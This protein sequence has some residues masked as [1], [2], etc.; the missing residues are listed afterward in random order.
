MQPKHDLLV[1]SKKEILVVLL[2]LILV[3]LFSFTIGLKLGKSLASKESPV[4]QQ[5]H[6]NPPLEEK[7]EA[8]DEEEEEEEPDTGADHNPQAHP[9]SHPSSYTGSSGTTTHSKGSVADSVADQKLE[10]EVKKEGIQSHRAITTELPQQPKKAS[11]GVGYTLQVG[12][13]KTVAEA[14]EEVA[15]LK[16]KGIEKAFYFEAEV[17]GKGTWYRVGI[18]VYKSKN[19]AERSGQKLKAQ[20]DFPQFIVQRIGE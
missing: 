10:E 14:T 17:P 7:A 12:A 16:R 4:V 13:Y 11:E 15:V 20:G 6:Q 19:D 9:S 3:A 8:T 18:G 5:E 1:F 2:L